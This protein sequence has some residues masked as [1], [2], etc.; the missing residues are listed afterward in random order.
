MRSACRRRSAFRSRTPPPPTLRRRT[1]VPPVEQM[2][3]WDSDI[4][5]TK[6]FDDTHREKES[7]RESQRERV[8]VCVCVCVCSLHT[9][10]LISGVCVVQSTHSAVGHHCAVRWRRVPARARLPERR[11]SRQSRTHLS[12]I[13]LLFLFHCAHVYVCVRVCVCS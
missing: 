2:W 11:Q 5:E 8:C 7:Q 1:T 9:V 13:S 3:L 12:I 6:C 10:L 4:I